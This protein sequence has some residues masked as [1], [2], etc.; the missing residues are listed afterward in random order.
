MVSY[1]K[2]EKM[3]YRL[4]A[5]IVRMVAITKKAII[6]A[7]RIEILSSSRFFGTNSILL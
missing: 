4:T 6:L 1:P 3:R 2:A 5:V 7:R